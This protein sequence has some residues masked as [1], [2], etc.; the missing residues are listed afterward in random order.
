MHALSLSLG[1]QRR[2]GAG[3][4]SPADLGA[5]LLAWWD[6]EDASTL[7]LDTGTVTTW[8]DKVAA[9]SPTQAVAGAKP[10]YSATGFNG[11]PVVTFDGVDDILSLASVGLLP[12]MANACEI[13][14]LV[15]QT[16]LVADTGSRTAFSYGGGSNDRRDVR[17]VVNSAVNRARVM[18]GNG[19]TQVTSD[20]NSVDLSGRHV[21]R[22]QIST[23]T[24]T[25]TV[26]A[27]A[28]GSTAVVPVTGTARL[29]L[30]G[31]STAAPATYWQGGINSIL[32]TAPLT[33]DQ[34]AALLAYLVARRG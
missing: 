19:V 23:T 30:G 28:A 27:T 16:A 5:S 8:A 26:D 18:A 3:A 13:W 34:S 22:A 32:V 10:A 14:A 24:M 12:T 2:A 17:R 31:T 25:I 1:L 11:R 6:A 7:T 4:F 29:A 20:N 21:M 15:D 33:S 9:L